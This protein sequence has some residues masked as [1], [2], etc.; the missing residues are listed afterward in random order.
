MITS[1]LMESLDGLQLISA[2]KHSNT[3][4]SSVH[5]FM[6]T[7]GEKIDE[8]LHRNDHPNSVVLKDE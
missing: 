4:N 3:L 2:L 5:I 8:L 1:V 6:L 7:S